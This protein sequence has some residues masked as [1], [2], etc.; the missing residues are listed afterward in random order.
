MT[1]SCPGRPRE[2][3]RRAHGGADA[4]G[5]DA[6]LGAKSASSRMFG[7]EQGDPLLEHP[8]GDGPAH[9]GRSAGPRGCA[10]P[11]SS[12]AA[13]SPSRSRMAPRSAGTA[14]KSRFRIMLE[15]LGQR[16][17]LERARSAALLQRWPAP[18]SAGPAPAASM[19]GLVLM[20]ESSRAEKIARALGLRLVLLAA[21]SCLGE[22]QL[23]LAQRDHVAVAQAPLAG[24]ALAVE[25][26]A[27]LAA[28]VG[29]E[30]APL[31]GGGSRR[32]G[33]RA[34]GRAGRCRSPASGRW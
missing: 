12:A 19:A 10:R 9:A 22:G 6:V 18:G 13:G 25:Q 7:E 3:Q 34:T 29:E 21:R 5:E 2:P 11:S 32:G 16:P 1:A 15:Q 24:H 30:E 31:L 20:S 23:V 4:G 17:V 27:V 14:S 8:A 26:G 33:G 28:Q